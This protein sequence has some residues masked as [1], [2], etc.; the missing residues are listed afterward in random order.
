MPPI[1]I[2]KSSDELKKTLDEIGGGP[3]TTGPFVAMSRSPG[4][5][6]KVA[7]LGDYLRFHNSLPQNIVEMTVL[8]TARRWTE[9]FEWNSHYPLAIK[10]GLKEDTA[11]AIA[12]GRR[13]VGMSQD[14]EIA[15]DFTTELNL[16]GGVSDPTYARAIGKFREQGVIDLIAVNGYFAMLG[17]VMNVART[18]LKPGEKPALKSLI[19]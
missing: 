14:E 7:P 16:N 5:L 2:E 18:P 11:K 3:R 1:P 8:M 19:R 6:A 9:Q 17:M 4:L 13:P 12:E 10:A 15:Y